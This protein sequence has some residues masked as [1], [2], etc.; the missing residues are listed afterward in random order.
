MTMDLARNWWMVAL[1]GVLGILFGL[2]ALVW[3]GIT[4]L[5]LVAL[6]GAYALVDG[7][8]AVVAAF[9]AGRSRFRWWLV[10]EGIAGISAGIATVFWPQ[11]TALVL[12][13]LVAAW[14]IVTG[15]LE[16]VAAIRL[17]K[18]ITGEWVLA[19][20]GVLSVGFGVLLLLFP[21]PGALSLVWLIGAYALAF[22][23]LLLVLAFRLRSWGRRAAPG[24][25]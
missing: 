20:T 6:F 4:L 2:I 21:G 5:V 7:I 12:L 24:A 11:I 18:V 16:I 13:V 19:L 15:V 3:P 9:R 22:G 17:R 1:R 8:F 23:I 10:L 25:A 14:A